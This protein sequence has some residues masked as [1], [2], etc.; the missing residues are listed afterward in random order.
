MSNIQTDT[1][2]TE[3]LGPPLPALL[4]STDGQ[5]RFSL[6]ILGWESTVMPCTRYDE[7]IICSLSLKTPDN[8]K[9]FEGPFMLRHE[10]VD[11]KSAV[12]HC[13][14]PDGYTFQSDF[15]E[16]AFKINLQSLDSNT[17]VLIHLQSPESKQN[18]INAQF[19]TNLEA[20]SQ[21]VKGL[22]LQLED[23]YSVL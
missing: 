22:E 12:E 15:M 13:L 23:F 16:T 11:L 17:T 9:N 2:E 21:F 14:K 3:R 8:E 1:Q 7:W 20:L 19:Q 5:Y 6:A 10:V 18:S 4:S